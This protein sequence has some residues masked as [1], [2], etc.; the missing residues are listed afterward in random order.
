MATILISNTKNN[1]NKYN[2]KQVRKMREITKNTT[3]IDDPKSEATILQIV[4]HQFSLEYKMRRT[5]TSNF[6]SIRQETKQE[7]KFNVGCSS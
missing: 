7:S 6:S 1:N 5:L 2:S 4:L 3:T